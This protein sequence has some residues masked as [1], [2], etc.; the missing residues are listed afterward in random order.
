M[1][2]AVSVFSD[3]LL[4]DTNSSRRFI[5]T[6]MVL[7]LSLVLIVVVLVPVVVTAGRIGYQIPLVRFVTFAYKLY[8]L[9][10]IQVM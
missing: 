10:C 2:V 4:F 5:R 9:K 1:A 3:K 8:Q 7:T 6:A